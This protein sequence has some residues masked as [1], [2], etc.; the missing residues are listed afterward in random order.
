MLRG[1]DAL[2]LTT[3]KWASPKGIAFLNT[4]R[5]EAGVKPSVEVKRPETPEPIE[6]EQLI[7]RNNENNEEQQ[8]RPE[9]EEPEAVKKPTTNNEDL[10]LKKAL[11]LLKGKAKA[12]GA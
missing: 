3:Q 1:G 10:Q 4:K 5:N 2:L 9:R 12:A 7:D 8:D 6:V 11:E